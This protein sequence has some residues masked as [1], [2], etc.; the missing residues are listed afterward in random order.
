MNKYVL[1]QEVV[2]DCLHRL[3]DQPIHRLYA[4]YL[5]LQQQSSLAGRNDNLRFPYTDF[6]DAYFRIRDSDKP[7]YVPFTQ[8]KSPDKA[9][10][11]FNSN[12]AGT[13]AASS[14]RSTSPLLKVAEI[15]EAGH[16]SRWR[17][18]EE[19]WKLARHYTLD[20]EHVPVESL[21]A[22]LYRD[23]AIET[24]EPSAYQ[25]VTT[26]AEDFGYNLNGSKFSHLYETGDSDISSDSFKKYG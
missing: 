26:F 25:L 6:F 16:D 22:Y 19:H 1:K 20:N 9:E 4:G 2:N 11:W 15:E 17:L 12:V 21:A 3:I 18:Q 8:A 10:L 5:C 24:D 14:L 13:Y 23:Y 7:Y